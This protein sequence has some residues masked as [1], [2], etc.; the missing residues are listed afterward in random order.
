MNEIRTILDQKKA[1]FDTRFQE[2]EFEEQYRREKISRVF[3]MN[4]LD[5]GLSYLGVD[6]ERGELLTRV[7]IPF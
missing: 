2:T 3:V 6:M 7:K 5:V 4:R 1:F